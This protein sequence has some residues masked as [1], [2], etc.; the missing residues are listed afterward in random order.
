[1]G[2]VWFYPKCLALA[3]LIKDEIYPFYPISV[4]VESLRSPKIK[5]RDLDSDIFIIAYEIGEIVGPQDHK[6]I[7][8]W[9]QRFSICW[10][11]IVNF[12]V[13]ELVFEHGREHMDILCEHIYNLGVTLQTVDKYTIH[14]YNNPSRNYD[15][16]CF[17]HNLHTN[18]EIICDSMSI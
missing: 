16:P 3:R 13:E 1:M 18:N 2:G 5:F 11:G 10:H 9:W 15:T 4:D 12:C 7:F 17:I 8:E 14:N 6:D